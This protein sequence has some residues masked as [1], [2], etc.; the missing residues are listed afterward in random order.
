MGAA[1][2]LMVWL[3]WTSFAMLLGAEL[4]CELA[5]ESKKGKIPEKPAPDAPI[6]L[7]LAA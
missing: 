5:K 2:A 3:Y 6:K 1:I 7:D 4:N